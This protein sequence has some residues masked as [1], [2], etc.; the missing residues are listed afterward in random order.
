VT[1][2]AT[3]QSPLQQCSDE[4]QC[5]GGLYCS[6]LGSRRGRCLTINPSPGACYGYN[7]TCTSHGQ[8]CAGFCDTLGVNGVAFVCSTSNKI[9]SD[10]GSN[11]DN[12]SSEWGSKTVETTAWAVIVACVVIVAVS[13]LVVK[14]RRNRAALSAE[15]ESATT[16]SSSGGGFQSRGQTIKT[17]LWSLATSVVS[18]QRSS[19]Y[20]VS[21]GGGEG[22]DH[23][24]VHP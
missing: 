13:V 17:R 23:E 1:S 19:S 5:C 20:N 2:T 24:C 9:P 8:C 3:C 18:G 4:E 22:E 12:A 7:T 11:G 16:G 15:N 21:N 10:Q 14:H 6:Y